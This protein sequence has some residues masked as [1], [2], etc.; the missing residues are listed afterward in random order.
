M[1]L[2][3]FYS[4]SE[5]IENTKRIMRNLRNY[6]VLESKLSNDIIAMGMAYQKWIGCFGV[7][8]YINLSFI[9]RI[10]IKYGIMNLVHAV[11]CRSDRCCLE[12][13]FGCIFSTE[14]PTLYNKKSL[15]GDIMK[16]QRWGYTYNEYMQH[17]KKGTVPRILVKVWTGR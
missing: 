3:F 5:N 6:Q 13:I 7:Q 4:D 9:E 11:K 2:W 10:E 16:Y 12:R 17:L 14:S 8:S 1:P 15:L